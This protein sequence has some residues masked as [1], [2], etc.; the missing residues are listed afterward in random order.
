MVGLVHTPTRA[1]RTR[2]VSRQT[3]GNNSD[4]AGAHNNTQ[5]LDRRVSQR[6]H[7]S[8][9]ES[10]SRREINIEKTDSDA[11]SESVNNRESNVLR[12]QE[13]DV[14]PIYPSGSQEAPADATPE[15]QP[16]PAAE[17]QAAHAVVADVAPQAAEVLPAGGVREDLAAPADP[18]R[19]EVQGAL[20]AVRPENPAATR[21]VTMEEMRNLFRA[22]AAAPIAPPP[23]AGEDHEDPAVFLRNCEEFFRRQGTEDN[24]KVVVVGQVLKGEAARWWGSFKNLPIGWAKFKDLVKARFNSDQQVF[25]PSAQLYGQVQG[26]RETVSLFWEKRCLLARRLLPNATDAE[27]TALLSEGLKGSIKKHLRSPVPTRIEDLIALAVQIEQDEIAEQAASKRPAEVSLMP[28]L[29]LAF[30]CSSKVIKLIVIIK[31]SP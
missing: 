12:H 25:H 22:L 26:E 16:I 5:S 15:V 19:H 21:A 20:D 23:Y 30:H 27:I 11:Q 6:N 10:R 2:S 14:I 31:A 24:Q 17:P 28:G 13:I 4:S 8:T 9:R 1:S 18:D 3:R 7:P 29:P